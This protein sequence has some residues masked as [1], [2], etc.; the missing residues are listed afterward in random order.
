MRAAFDGTGDVVVITGGASGI[1][2]AVADG[3][4]AAG[5]AVAVLDVV[6][7]P[8][9]MDPR[10]GY[11]RVDV[12]DR[13]ALSAAAHEIQEALGLVTGLVCGAV[14]Q[15][16]SGV[17]DLEPEEWRRVQSINLDG[18]LWTCQ[19]F[20]PQMI[21]AGGGSVVI[22]TSGIAT[23]GWPEAAAYSTT[24][25]AAQGLARSLAA[26]V[27]DSGVRVNL[28]SPGVVDTPQYRSA[29]DESDRRHWAETV[30]VGVPEDVV[31]PILFLLSDA[32]TMTGSLLARERR[33]GGST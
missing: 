29:N 6:E 12:S 11:H 23:A 4:L 14:V 17:L 5:A 3:A 32:A 20:V 2:R 22:F 25:A 8:H 10:I 16:R 30:G 24:K 26:E 13:S 31:D 7:R 15:P 18:V 28:I 9:D 33:F 19:A 21:E 1:S 27:A